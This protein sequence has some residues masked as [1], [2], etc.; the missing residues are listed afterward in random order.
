MVLGGDAPDGRRL[1]WW[2]FVASRA[3][4]IVQSSAD[5]TAQNLGQ[6]PGDT[7]FIPLPVRNA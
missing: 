4:T 1:L 5:W 2:N 6:V 3:E 7:E